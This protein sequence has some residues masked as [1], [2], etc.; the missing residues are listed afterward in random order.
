MAENEYLD[1]SKAR[2]WQSVAQVIWESGSLDEVAD[3][4]EDCFY[5]TLRQIHKELPFAEMI[6]ALES[7]ED[8]ARIAHST[9]TS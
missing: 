1:S 8:L 7:P 4:V 6:E 3:R 9:L 5:K 2:R